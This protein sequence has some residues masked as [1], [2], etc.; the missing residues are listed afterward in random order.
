MAALPTAMLLQ[1]TRA[2]VGRMLRADVF[3]LGLGLIL[4][5]AA[6]AAMAV[7]ARSSRGREPS[8]PW[9][10]LFTF[11]YG[12]RLLARTDTF[13]LL[14]YWSPTFWRYAAATITYVIPIPAVLY[15]REIFPRWRRPL[16]WAAAF[17]VVF[18][19]GAITADALLRRPDSAKTPNNLIAILFMA[20]AL[21]LLFR[22]GWPPSRDLRTLRVGLVSLAVTAVVDNLRGLGALSSPRFDVEPLGSTVLIACLGAM[23]ARRVYASAQRLLAIDK[24]LSIARQIQIGILPRSMP[25]VAGLAV[26]ARYQPMTAVAGD[27]YDFLQMDERRLGVLVADVS[28]HGVPAALIASMVKVAVAAQKPQADSPAAVL[29]GMNET[30]RGQ[31]GGQYVTAAYLFLDRE[32]GVMR[33]SAAGHPPLLRWRHAEVAHELEEN[34]LPLGLMEVADYRQLEQPLQ[35]GDRFL[36]YTDGL[37]DAANAAGEFF[38][39]ERVKTAV[40]AGAGLSA[41]AVADLILEKTRIWAHPA[42]SDDVTLVLVDCV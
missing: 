25:S 15:L 22:K 10:A 41:D 34:G 13:P 6:V 9:F 30:L 36:L 7:Y 19:A 40:A 2:D 42:A 11:L 33:Y 1:V 5:A 27:F 3:Y 35:A 24:E 17:L 26:A 23:A 31:L 14:F 28:G 39:L 8:L 20:G 16:A 4:L 18:A 32:A 29:A 37:V 21:P 12:L 38:E